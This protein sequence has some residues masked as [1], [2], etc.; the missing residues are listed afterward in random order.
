MAH[1]VDHALRNA[2]KDK[3]HPPWLQQL[4]IQWQAAKHALGS[5]R[6]SGSGLSSIDGHS[7]GNDKRVR[8]K[9]SLHALKEA[10]HQTKDALLAAIGLLPHGHAAS[11]EDSRLYWNT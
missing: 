7:L 9:S 6:G 8:R 2:P 11:D 4:Q 1:V 10:L 3:P 5:I